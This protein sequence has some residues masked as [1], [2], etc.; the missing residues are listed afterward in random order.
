MLCATSS[1]QM[2]T[3]QHDQQLYN[4]LTAS[5]DTSTE[6]RDKC[7]LFWPASP[8]CQSKVLHLK[9]E[10]TWQAMFTRRRRCQCLCRGLRA[11][12]L[13][14]ACCP[15]LRTAPRYLLGCSSDD[16]R[17]DHGDRPATHWSGQVEDQ[18]SVGCC[19]CV[20]DDALVM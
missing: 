16:E 15:P 9:T 14:A 3:C 20:Y 13:L 10:L 8:M 1:V 6:T 5:F 12:S 17:S 11:P 18:R 4:K 19:H 2:S 7:F